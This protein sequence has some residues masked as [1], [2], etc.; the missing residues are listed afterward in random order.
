MTL[1]DHTIL[2]T[3]GAT[4][5]GLALA[6]RF[7]D[8]GST[9]VVCGRRADVLDA[10]RAAHPGLVTRVADVATAEGR[11]ALAAWATDAFPALDV[12]VHNAGIQNRP[13]LA[14]LA[15]DWERHRQ[16]IA[17]NLDAPIHLT[18]LLAEHLARQARPAVVMVTSGLSFGPYASAP[19]YSATKAA[20]H[21]F[22]VSLRYLLPTVEVVEIVPPAVRTDLGGPGLHDFG[23]DVDAFADSVLARVAAGETEVGYGTSETRRLATR[24]ETDA[25]VEQ[26]NR[27]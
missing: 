22:T 1:S 23:V 27:R 5:I 3:G 11:E 14:A 12:V 24:E 26:M 15:T 13:T 4:G 25:A 9:V 10:A 2:V 16:E 20:L 7:L 6:R 17:I 8:A 21:S 19:V 18:A